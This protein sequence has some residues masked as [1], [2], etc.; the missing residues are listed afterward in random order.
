[1]L[2]HHLKLLKVNLRIENSDI[3]KNNQKKQNSKNKNPRRRRYGISYLEQISE[4]LIIDSYEKG[5]DIIKTL[6]KNTENRNLP[7]PHEDIRGNN[8]FNE[9]L[10]FKEI[11]IPNMNFENDNLKGNFL[12]YIDD[13]CNSVFGS[14]KKL[15]PQNAHILKE[16]NSK[17]INENIQNILK[18]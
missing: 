8:I 12:D 6:T 18:K 1:M 5:E 16:E 9:G 2:N 10:N 14:V 15:S 11:D 17:S 7:I 13:V 3:S 4:V